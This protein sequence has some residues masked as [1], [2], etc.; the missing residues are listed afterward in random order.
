MGEIRISKLLLPFFTTSELYPHNHYSEE[1]YELLP[2]TEQNIGIGCTLCYDADCFNEGHC[3]NSTVTYKCVCPNGFA[4]DD[5]S[6]DI[7]ECEHNQCDNNSTCIDQI[8]KYECKCLAGY[9]GTQ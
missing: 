1:F 6:I 2:P 7:N 3:M 5:C 4:A 8:G 9:E